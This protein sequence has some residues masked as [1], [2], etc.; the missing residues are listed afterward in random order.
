ML[1]RAGAHAWTNGFVVSGLV[2]VSFLL[3]SGTYLGIKAK[4]LKQVLE[5]LAT[6]GADRPAPS[7]VPPPFVAKLP[8]LNAGVA[9]GVIFDMV[10]KPASILA[11]LAALAIG[12]LVS[13]MINRRRV[14]SP[15]VLP[16]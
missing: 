15:S 11:A 8:V 4:A 3:G 1:S 10:T 12:A 6:V 9:L 2:G 5:N 7:L 13:L 14:S 16:A